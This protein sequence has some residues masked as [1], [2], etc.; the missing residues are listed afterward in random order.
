[1]LALRNSGSLLRAE[2]LI[3]FQ[4]LRLHCATLAA[5]LSQSKTRTAESN[6]SK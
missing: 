2:T 1:M 5:K 3:L 6:G 4:I